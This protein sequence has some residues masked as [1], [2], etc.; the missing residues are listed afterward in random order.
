MSERKPLPARY[1]PTGVWPAEM[2]ADMVAAYLD[3]RNTS[4]LARAVARGDAPPPTGYHGTGRS[5]EPV[6]AKRH[7]DFR[8][9][10]CRTD[11]ITSDEQQPTLAALV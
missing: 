4:E 6:W 9:N 8:I 11:A 2:R 3:Y 10:P 5:K 1:P 7:V